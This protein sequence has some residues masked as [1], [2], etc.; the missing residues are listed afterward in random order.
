MIIYI[1]KKLLICYR[2]IKYTLVHF[3][4]KYLQVLNAKGKEQILFI[5][6]TTSIN[7]VIQNL[8]DENHTHTHTLVCAF[9]SE[10]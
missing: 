6:K 2:Y 4:K 5:T 8:Q 3:T 7:K 1:L 9:Y 10:V